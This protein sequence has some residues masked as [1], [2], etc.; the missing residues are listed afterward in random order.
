VSDT[1]CNAATYHRVVAPYK[2]GV[3]IDLPG[4]PGCSDLFV[5]G[6]EIAFAEYRERGFLDRPVELLVREYDA[7]PWQAGKVNVDVY[8]EL[9][10]QGVLAVA[11]PMTTDNGLALLPELDRQQVSSISICGS[12]EYAGDFAF[13]LPNG[14]MADEAMVIASWLRH[15]GLTRFAIL[16]ETPSQIGYEYTAHMYLA[17]EAL[18]LEIALDQGINVGASEA[19]IDAAIARLKESA[20]DAVVYLGLGRFEGGM[21]KITIAFERSGWNPPRFMCASFVRAAYSEQRARAFTGWVGIDQID[22]DNPL[23]ARLVQAYEDRRGHTL[24]NPTSVFSCGY[25]IG[26]CL[27]IALGRMRIA[28]PV[29]LRDALETITRLPS[30]TGGRGTIISFSK[31]NHRGFHGPNYLILRSVQAGRSVFEGAAPVI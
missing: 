11:G 10:E 23:F 2:I 6:L 21:E 15:R 22:E 1:D 9:A 25:D 12:Q 18:E 7:Q 24:A 14:G 20:P 28:T 30:A 29:A 13:S 31:R 19:E 27:A 17:A 8:R 4:D 5:E 3:M 26:R 16:R